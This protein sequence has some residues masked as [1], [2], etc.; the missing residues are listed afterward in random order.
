MK[1]L[2]YYISIKIIVTEVRSI[3]DLVYIDNLDQ[4]KALSDPL[5][6]NIITALGAQ[7]KNAQ[8][9]ADILGISRTRIHYH[10]N[11]L[12]EMG[13]IEVV[14][15]DIING[16]VQKYYLPKAQAFVPAPTIF[17]NL[18]S[19]E[20]V[21]YDIDSSKK[22]DFMA[23]FEKLIDKYKTND[24]SGTKIILNCFNK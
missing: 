10:L 5:R 22:A 17:Q 9:V 18:F 7:K 8:Q 24:S 4:V 6:V 3:K 12:E 15:T 23:D 13:F 20:F 16:I 2:Y 11:I 21:E 1:L 14:D 19:D